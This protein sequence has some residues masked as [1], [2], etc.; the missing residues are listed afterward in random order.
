MGLAALVLIVRSVGWELLVRTLKPA[1]VYLP[2]I[3]LLE[4]GRA[5]SETTAGALALGGAR[6]KVP[7]TTLFIA[8]VIGQSL[9]SLAPAPRAVNETIKAT[10]IAPHVGTATATSVGV[11]NQAATLVAIG[12]FSIPCAVAVATLSSSSVW[13]VALVVHAVVLVATGVAILAVARAGRVGR[14]LQKKIPKLGDKA[15]VFGEHMRTVGPVAHGPA[16][17][18]MINRVCQATQYG[19]AA[20]AVGIDVGV[21]KTLA[22]QGVAMVANAV[23]VM[24]P[25]GLGTT[26]GAFSLAAEL[27]GTSVAQATAVAL[28][29]RANQ[30]VW[31]GIGSVLLFTVPRR[32]PR[33]PE[34]SPGVD[35]E[36]SAGETH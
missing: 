32:R 30:L 9:S 27:L 25:G 21:A 10:M 24:V 2:W 26:D 17:A 15:H 6:K 1:L 20:Y 13:L 33:D 4:V 34:A 12:V 16:A 31:L 18:L 5:I 7:L 35:I 23:G 36:R 8:N 11:I 28:L 29:M 19:I 14:W 22:A 3:C